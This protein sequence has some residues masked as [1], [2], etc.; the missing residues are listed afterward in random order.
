VFSTLAGARSY[1]VT[2]NGGALGVLTFKVVGL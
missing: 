2:A 1:T